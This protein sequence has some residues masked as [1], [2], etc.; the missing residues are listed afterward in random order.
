MRSKFG[1]FWPSWKTGLKNIIN[2]YIIFYLFNIQKCH[3]ARG[4]D[5]L[6]KVEYNN[7]HLGAY[8]WDNSRALGEKI[9]SLS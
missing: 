7:I 1:I 5:K 9:R 8:E 6:V 4:G 2:I 3:K